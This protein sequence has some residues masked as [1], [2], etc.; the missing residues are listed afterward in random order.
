MLFFFIFKVMKKSVIDCDFEKKHSI[1]PY[2]V[3]I[4]EERKQRKVKLF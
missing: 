3:S 2:Q 1:P 4:R